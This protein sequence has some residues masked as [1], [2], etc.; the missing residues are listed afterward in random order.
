MQFNFTYISCKDQRILFKQ[1]Q[2]SLNN[3]YKS[4]NI[5]FFFFC[6]VNFSKYIFSDMLPQNL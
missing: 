6:Q 3:N 5:A 4:C 1:A 2:K